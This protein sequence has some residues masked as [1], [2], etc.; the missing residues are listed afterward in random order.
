VA[1]FGRNYSD[2]A[3]LAVGLA[4]EIHDDD[5]FEEHRLKRLQELTS[6]DPNAFAITK[7]YL[8]SATV[9]RVRAHDLSFLGDFLD[10]WFQEATQKR[11]HGILEQLKNKS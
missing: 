5:G 2:D 7:R 8:R 4:H 10:T 3:A 6:K 1:L 11:I 9:E